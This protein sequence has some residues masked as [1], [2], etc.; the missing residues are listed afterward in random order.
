MTADPNA[1]P[2]ARLIRDASDCDEAAHAVFTAAVKDVL[3]ADGA[4]RPK[5][6]YLEWHHQYIWRNGI[7]SLEGPTTAT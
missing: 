2:R 1:Q 6:D 4:H 3:L 5:R 7:G